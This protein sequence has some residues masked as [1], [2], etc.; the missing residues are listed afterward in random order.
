MQIAKAPR[1]AIGLLVNLLV[2]FFGT[3]MLSSALGR[4]LW[5]P[6]SIQALL[7]I[8]YSYDIVTAA[9]L[10]FI[11]ARR[12]KTQTAKWIWIIAGLWFFTR[13]L[14]LLSSSVSFW[15]QFSGTACSQGMRAMGCM[16][17]FFFTIPFVRTIFY[18]VGTWLAFRFSSHSPS[19]LEDALFGKFHKH[20]WPPVDEQP[21]NER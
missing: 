1:T 7:R 15:S 3:A 18:S 16:N 11:V 20:T 14:L 10:G 6:H 13:A 21:T 5:H 17:W 8:S 12:F 9:L 4:G 2:A 19:G